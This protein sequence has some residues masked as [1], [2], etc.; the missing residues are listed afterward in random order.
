MIKNTFKFFK[1]VFRFLNNILIKDSWLKSSF[2]HQSIYRDKKVPWLTYPFI[3]FIE[4]KNFQNLKYLEFGSGNSTFYFQD[5]VK[6]IYSVEFDNEYYKRLR[7]NL[8]NYSN[9]KLFLSEKN[10]RNINALKDKKFDIILID[11][12]LRNQLMKDSYNLITEKG[13]IILDDS[14][15][16]YIEG[17]DFLLQRNFKKLDF[18]GYN[19]IA[20]KK[21]CTSVFYR[22]KNI[23]NL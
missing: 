7:N 2:H 13:I 6:I 14:D 9:V 17:I 16:N 10:N 18:W 22:S 20:Y 4:N 5:K 11:G 19:P 23:L 1:R 21:S 12:G 15:R 3:D 8:S